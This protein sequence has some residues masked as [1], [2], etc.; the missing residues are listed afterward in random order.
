VYPQ[1]LIPPDL[2]KLMAQGDARHII[3]SREPRTLEEILQAA[4]D[5][6]DETDRREAMAADP[7][8]SSIGYSAADRETTMGVNIRT[9]EIYDA[10][11]PVQPLHDGPGIDALA[12]VTP[13]ATAPARWTRPRRG[14]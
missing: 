1:P 10:P 11:D 7:V 3:R 5:D 13:V 2:R 14:T 6:M 12:L 4:S 9:G 8:R